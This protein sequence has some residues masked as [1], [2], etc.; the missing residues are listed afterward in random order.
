MK[1]NNEEGIRNYSEEAQ[2]ILGKPTR[3]KTS[4]GKVLEVEVWDGTQ[5]V[6]VPAD[7]QAAIRAWA[8][9]K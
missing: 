4:E 7:K 8:E 5:F 9:K 1:L 3:V 6:D 2:A